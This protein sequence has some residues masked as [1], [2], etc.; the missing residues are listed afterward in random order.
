M[1]V[2]H[3]ADGLLAYSVHPGGI[4]TRLAEAMHQDT[5][6]ALT[7]NPALTGDT[8]AFLTHERRPWLAGRYLSCTRDMEE[9]L[10]REDEIS[11]SEKLKVRL[12]L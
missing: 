2:E 10:A 4:M 8:I 1:L 5:H 6:S 11:G 3:A 7:D 9:L 12:V